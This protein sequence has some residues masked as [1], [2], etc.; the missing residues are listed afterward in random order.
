VSNQQR[1]DAG[2]YAAAN[3]G[4]STSVNSATDPAPRGPGAN[5]ATHTPSDTANAGGLGAAASIAHDDDWG[6][7]NQTGALLSHSGGAGR[8]AGMG[9]T[10]RDS[11]APRDYSAAYRSLGF[12]SNEVGSGQVRTSQGRPPHGSDVPGDG[13][14]GPA[15]DTPAGGVPGGVGDAAGGAGDAVAGAGGIGELADVAELAA[16]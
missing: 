7:S 1:D 3:A 9:S 2:R 16:I 11:I 5:I 12:G 15:G 6:A 8:G 10:P 4:G 13:V 14:P